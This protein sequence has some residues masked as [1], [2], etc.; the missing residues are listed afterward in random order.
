MNNTKNIMTLMMDVAGC[1]ETLL[2]FKP[3]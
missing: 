2:H 3:D 1:S